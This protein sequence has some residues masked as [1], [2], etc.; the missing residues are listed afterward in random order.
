MFYKE[1]FKNNVEPE[2]ASITRLGSHW[3][4]WDIIPASKTT[5]QQ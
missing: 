1:Y 3:W 4:E 2:L 5:I